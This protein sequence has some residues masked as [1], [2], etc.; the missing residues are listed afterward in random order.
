VKRRGPTIQAV[1]E[2]DS[3]IYV[4]TRADGSR[5]WHYWPDPLLELEPNA[6]WITQQTIQLGSYINV[7][8]YIR[9][10]TTDPIGRSLS[11]LSSLQAQVRPR[12][13]DELLQ[14]LRSAGR[15]SR[16]GTTSHPALEDP[17]GS[18]QEPGLNLDPA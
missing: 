11:A 10:L 4:L 14:E 16:S 18:D 13:D 17:E 5:L 3:T 2:P 12:L 9:A 7:N 6:R 1:D 8:P 15:D